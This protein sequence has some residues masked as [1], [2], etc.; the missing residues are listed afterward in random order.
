MALCTTKGSTIAGIVSVVPA[1][2]EDNSV[3]D[4]IPEAE[5]EALISHTGIRYKR[6]AEEQT[7]V[8]DLFQSAVDQLLSR[9]EWEKNSI[10][11]LICVTQSPDQLIPS[12]SCRLHGDLNFPQHTLCFDINSGCSGFVYGLYTVST[13]LSGMGKSGARAILCCGDISSQLTETTD[14]SVR[15]VFSD[16]V[17]AIGIEMSEDPEEITGYFNLETAGKGQDAIRMEKNEEGIAYMRLNGIDVFNYSVKYVPQNIT[18]L[19]SYTGKEMTFPDQFVFHQANKLINESIRRK[20]GIDPEKVPYS[21]YEY[22]NTASASIPLT[23]GLIGRDFPKQSGWTLVSGFGVGFSMASGLIRFS[24]RVCASP[25]E[26]YFTQTQ[27]F[28]CQT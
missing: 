20:L 8:K 24:P 11:V 25:E 18:N 13:M 5:R 7:S 28:P 1:K 14:K 4:L 21:L 16:A 26:Y 12:V 9:L 27:S 17:S 6:I 19:L 22:G 23:M 3:L 15:S 10:D 2:Q